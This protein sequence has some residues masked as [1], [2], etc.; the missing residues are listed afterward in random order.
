SFKYDKT[1]DALRVQAKP[2]T[3]PNVEWMTF[4]FP[5]VSATSATIELAWEKLRVPFQVETN[6]VK[7]AVANIEKVVPTATDW[8]V[9]YDAAEFAVNQNL[10]KKQAMDWVN[11]SIALKETF[12]NLRLKADMLAKDGNTKEAISL[13]EKAVALGKANNDESD[14]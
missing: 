1:K 14:A 8:S 10:D 5:D 3:G 7:K 11:R 2:Q 13:A 12:W 9:P 4:S 6:T